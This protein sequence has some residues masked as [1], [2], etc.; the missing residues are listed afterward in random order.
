[1]ADFLTTIAK[2]RRERLER[3]ALHVPTIELRRDAEARAT[4][5]RAFIAALRR[6]S[7]EPLRVIAE[8]KRASPSAGVL[9]EEFNPAEIGKEYERVGAAAISVLTEPLRFQGSIEDLRVVREAVSVPVLLKDFVVHERQLYEARAN[10]ADAALLIVSLLS[11]GQLRDYAALARE[12]GLELLIEVHERT[13]VERAIALEGAV[14]VNNRNLRTLEM[15][16]HHASGIL[17][18]IPADRV[19]IAE[20]GYSA[21]EEIRE[22]ERVGA[23][24]VLVGEI[25]LKAESIE[26]AFTTLF[27]LASEKKPTERKSG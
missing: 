1:M 20:S 6:P 15:R 9:K 21:R 16:R 3:E 13:E 14:G 5:T 4:D 11:P 17:P 23:D 27:G 26:K 25:L 12:I 10:G 8:I 19:R 7:G 22:L 24:G 18:L 2:E